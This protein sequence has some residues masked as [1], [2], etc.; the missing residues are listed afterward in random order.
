MVI[1]AP[2][3]V[4]A[5]SCALPQAGA[6]PPVRALHFGADNT[7]GDR[8]R[9]QCPRGAGKVPYPLR[10]RWASTPNDGAQ[11]TE[12]SPPGGRVR[13][14]RARGRGR[15]PP[16]LGSMQQ[17]QKPACEGQSPLLCNLS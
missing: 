4:A 5:G 14:V 13:P 1:T 16:V 7:W 12:S 8:L 9:R 11:E 17:H 6:L 15:K 3:A 10:S 2:I